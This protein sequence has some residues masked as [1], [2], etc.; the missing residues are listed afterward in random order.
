MAAVAA[1]MFAGVLFAL[2]IGSRNDSHA[3][4]PT[5]VEEVVFEYIP[6]EEP[7]SIYIAWPF[8]A[9]TR[10]DFAAERLGSFAPQE[11][12]VQHESDGWIL[13]ADQDEDHWVYTNAN[14]I[15]VGRITGVFDE[16]GGEMVSRINAQVVD[17]IERRGNWIK[18]NTYLGYKWINLEFEPPTYEFE[19]FMRQFGY[20]IA[21]FYENMATGFT[22]IHNP[23]QEFFYA[24]IS[25]EVA[26]SQH[27]HYISANDAGTILREIFLHVAG[28]GWYEFGANNAA[29][30]NPFAR[31]RYPVVIKSGR[32][33]AP[34]QAWHEIGIVYSQSP[35]TLAILSS[36]P[37]GYGDRRVYAQIAEFVREFNDKWFVV[38]DEF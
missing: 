13:I 27:E 26:E 34:Y 33:P 7:K 22:M 3:Y 35:Y 2:F 24:G 1:G 5:I 12:T 20:N 19:E 38:A 6:I 9:Y 8:I 18:T 32:S 17:A 11:I 15:Y 14:K 37:G 36:W 31:L 28:G 4:V 25:S 29:S 16:I 30:Y 10:P 23:Y 21:I